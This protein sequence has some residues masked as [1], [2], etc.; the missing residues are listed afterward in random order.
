MRILLVFLLSCVSAFGADTGVRV[1]STVTTNKAGAVLTTDTF[2]RG[3]QTNLVRVTKVQSGAVVFRS[4]QFCHNGEPVARFSFRDGA[5][6]FST[7][8]NSP[9]RVV[10]EFLR[11]EDVRCVVI[12]GRGFI[13]GFYP[14]NGVYYPAPDSDLEMQD[15]RR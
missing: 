4:Q 10:V 6:S 13:D 15:Y 8:P 11:S 7:V 12:F 14:T 1:I 2:T 9:Y 5:Q 3:G